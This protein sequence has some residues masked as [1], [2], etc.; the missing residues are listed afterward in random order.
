[1]NA[2]RKQCL[3]GRTAFGTRITPSNKTDLSPES[4]QSSRSGV[5]NAC[6][7]EQAVWQRNGVE[8]LIHPLC[9]RSARGTVHVYLAWHTSRRV[10]RLRRRNIAD[11]DGT[12]VSDPRSS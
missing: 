6:Q 7:A 1:M 9:N 12:E 3:R 4:L 11:L 8:S 5:S 2:D 10:R